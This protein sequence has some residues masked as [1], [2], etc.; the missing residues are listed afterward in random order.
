MADNECVEIFSNQLSEIARSSE[1][2]DAFAERNGVPMKTGY[3]INVALD[4]LLTNTISYGYA[5]QGEHK[6]EL[7]MSLVHGVWTIILTDSAKAF[8]PLDKADPDVNVPL[9][10]RQIGGLGIYFV[11]KLMDSV[12]YRREDGRNIITLKKHVPPAAGAQK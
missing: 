8:N 2:V 1:L 12:E 5:D 3:E 11:R 10:E 6:I 4:E 9:E 7:R